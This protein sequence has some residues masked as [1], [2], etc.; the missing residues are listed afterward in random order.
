MVKEMLRQFE[1]LKEITTKQ[2]SLLLCACGLAAVGA[3]MFVIND[4]Q[5][6]VPI[7]LLWIGAILLL[8]YAIFSICKDVFCKHFP[9]SYP[10]KRSLYGEPQHVLK[11]VS[12]YV[13]PLLFKN[14]HTKIEVYRDKIVMSAFRRC[15]VITTP[16]QIKIIP[17]IWNFAVD[18]RVDNSAVRC[19]IRRKRIIPLMDWVESRNKQTGKND[20]DKK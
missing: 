14:I 5:L 6:F 4:K 10:E 12:S 15:L 20:A 13:G 9:Y 17:G 19:Y 2:K 1:F 3:L 16:E 8:Y 11:S 7:I 18:C